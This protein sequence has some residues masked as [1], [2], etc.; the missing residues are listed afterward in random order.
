M[1]NGHY[2]AIKRNEV[3][4]YM[5]HIENIMLTEINLTQKDKYSVI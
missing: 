3:L 4:I 5:K 1:Y 2:Y